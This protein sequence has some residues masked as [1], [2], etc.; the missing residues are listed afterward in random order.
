MCGPRSMDRSTFGPG[1]LSRRNCE[2]RRTGSRG[3]GN[4][5]AIRGFDVA[6]EREI[7]SVPRCFSVNNWWLTYARFVSFVEG[8]GFMGG[9]LCLK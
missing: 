8:D 7:K 5:P 2:K 4:T 6:L 3:A 9:G 1:F